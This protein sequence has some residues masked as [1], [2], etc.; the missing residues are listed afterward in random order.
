MGG[1]VTTRTLGALAALILFAASPAS[2]SGHGPVFGLATPTNAKGGWQLDLM[3]GTRISPEES[4]AMTRAMLSFGVT[5]DVQISVTA[6][7]VFKFAPLAPVRG[8]G[9]MAV[10]TDVETI[11]V[12][13]FHRRGTNVGTR[14]E[15]TAYAGLTIPA[16][17]AR[18]AVGLLNRAPGVYT[19]VATGMASRSHYVWVG[20]QNVHFAEADGDQKP[21]IFTYSVVWGYRPPP[22][23]KEYPHWDWRFFVEM[24]G[25][26]T[27]KLVHGGHQ[28][29]GTNGHQ[30]GLGPSL[31]GIYKNY[32]ISG[33]VQFPVLRNVGSAFARETVHIVVNFSR[34]F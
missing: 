16:Q 10:S 26:V 34:F 25:D 8:M 19:A 14:F 6:P 27:S 23:R 28:M 18:S 7:Y 33:G 22:F 11:G 20:V 32:A 5:E 12:W 9:M 24:N 15:S 30:I 13:R 31:L 2:A 4:G 29:P 3:S 21:N 17:R 1:L